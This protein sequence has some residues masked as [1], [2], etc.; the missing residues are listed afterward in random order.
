MV[1][2]QA[3]SDAITKAFKIAI[4]EAMSDTLSSP[5]FELLEEAKEALPKYAYA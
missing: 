5:D 1:H 3:K 2:V 4:Q